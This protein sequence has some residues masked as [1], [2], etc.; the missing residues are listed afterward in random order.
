MPVIHHAESR[1]TETP[2]AVMTTLASPTLG[3]AGLAVWRV[4]MRPGASGPLHAFDAEQVW[5][6]LDG[7]ATVE[8]EGGTHVL[9]P[10]DTVVMPAD[11]ARRVHADPEAGFAAIVAATPGAGASVPGGTE[12][13]VPAWVV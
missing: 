4:D 6:V 3:G 1:R 13:T 5:T 2:N 10:G 11:V 12:K 9:V 8:I 7:G